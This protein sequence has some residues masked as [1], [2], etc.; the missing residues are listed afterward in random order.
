M[1]ESETIWYQCQRC[2]NCCQWEGDVVLTDREVHEISAFLGM[3]V[4]DFVR[5][6]TRVRG[7]RQGLSLIDKEG[8]TECIMLD[9]R[10]CRLQEVKPTQCRGFPNRWNFAGWREVCEAVPAPRPADD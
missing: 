7:N 3:T 4:Y 2:T 9:G 6:F 1:A 10:D 8:T 5:D